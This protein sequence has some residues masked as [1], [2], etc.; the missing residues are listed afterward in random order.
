MS[1]AQR[2]LRLAYC[3]PLNPAPSGIS[4]YSEELLPFLAQYAE[5]TV[6]VDDGLRPTN[7]ALLAAC[8]VQ[9]LRRLPRFQRRAAFDS[10]LYHMGNSPA[11]AA[12]WRMAQQVPGVVVLHELVFHHFMLWYAANV[13]HDVQHYVRMMQ[14]LYGDAGAHMAQ[15]MIRSRFS[16]AAFDFPCVEPILASAQAVLAHN[17]YLLAQVQRRAP[18]L[19]QALVPM[20]V[21]LPPLV[22]QAAARAR[23]GL[24]LD[25]PL[26]AAFGHINAWKRMESSLRALATLRAEGR[27]ARLLLVGSVSLNYDLAGLVARLGLTDAVTIT[28][29]V[30]QAQFYDYVAAADICLN[31]RYPTAGETSASLL[32]LLGAARPT[33]VSAVGSFAELPP[34][35]AAQVDLD[36]AEAGQLVAYC[37]RLLDDPP[38]AA[39]LG[40]AARRFVADQHTLPRAAASMA[41]AVAAFLGRPA[42]ALL[43]AEPLWQPPTV[44]TL[45]PAPP[46][47]ARR[48]PRFAW[49]QRPRSTPP[50]PPPPP[51][52]LSPLLQ[53]AAAALADLD[54]R[55]SDTALLQRVA[56]TIL[57][58]S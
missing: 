53:A 32:R 42:P 55:E 36:D 57:E 37:R 48:S 16:D 7:P 30:P 43:R 28:G 29:Y 35:V 14:Q 58:L 33:L 54:L 49:P 27:P 45:P 4:D 34:H 23:L 9:P 19:P 5:V 8:D 38:F 41:A 20:G 39:A 6:F 22:P 3:S 47:A 17:R 31:L 25:Q 24:P 12:I 40:A 2:P 51:A 26:L 10:V 18:Q 11:H 50:S 52:A 46:A 13:R 1:A 15:L 56:A 44:A 21:P